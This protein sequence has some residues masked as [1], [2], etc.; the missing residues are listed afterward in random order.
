M[1]SYKFLKKLYVVTEVS[2]L[3]DQRW[4]PLML[5]TALINIIH[6]NNLLLCKYNSKRQCLFTLYSVSKRGI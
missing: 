1:Q 2:M 6:Y 3:S 4:L 5:L